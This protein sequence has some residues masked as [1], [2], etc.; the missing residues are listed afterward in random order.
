MRETERLKDAEDAGRD[1][2]GG[3]MLEKREGL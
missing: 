1:V 3:L 2:R